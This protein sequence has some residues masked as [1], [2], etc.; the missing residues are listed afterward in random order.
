MKQEPSRTFLESAAWRSRGYIPHFDLPN[1]IQT[2]TFRLEDSVPKSLIEQWKRELAW[3]HHHVKLRIKLDKYEDSGYGACWLSGERVASMVEQTILFYDGKRYRIIAGCIMPNHV[4]VIIEIL[5][6][7]F[8]AD[9]MHSWKSYSAH[10]AN[11]ILCRSGEFWFR[12]YFDRFIRN[13]EHLAQAI[14]YVEN[15]PVK[16]GL[17]AAK[18]DWQWSSAWERRRPA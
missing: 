8:L 7:W 15:N 1:L 6:G 5:E 3:D 2:I 13:P 18:E 12:E 11:K 10:A 14:E 16:A 4:H 9:I 17:V